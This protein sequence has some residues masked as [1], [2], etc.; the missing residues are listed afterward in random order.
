MHTTAV[1]HS[2]HDQRALDVAGSAA[3]RA[4][5]DARAWAAANA[6][7]TFFV[8]KGALAVHETV[9]AHDRHHD[10]VASADLADKVWLGTAALL[11]AV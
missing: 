4:V 3:A 10:L 7:V 2:V 5:L 9:V 8:H 1:D 6:D 11:N